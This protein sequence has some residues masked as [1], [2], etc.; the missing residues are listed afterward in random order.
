MA[1]A[2]R[3]SDWKIEMEKLKPLS[4]VCQPDIRYKGRVDLDRTT[5]LV[6]ETTIESLY[7]LIEPLILNSNVPNDV[8]SHFEISKNL[9]LYAWFVYSFNV[10]AAMQ[11][12]ASL[13]MALRIKLN[14]K[15]APFKHLIDKAFN[16][17]KL[18]NG[19]GPPI[20]LSMV[21]SRMRNDLAHGSATMHGQGISVLQ[22][23]AEL[24]NELF[25]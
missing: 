1:K 11:S 7:S 4:E 18:H 20:D 23:C 6:S 9:A 8:R 24:I 5:G 19:P 15:K 10:V 13:E 22:T 21:L 12:F 17:R 14:D 2:K 16:N 3:R 25:V